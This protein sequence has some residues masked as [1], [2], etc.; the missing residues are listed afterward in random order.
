MMLKMYTIY[1]KKTKLYHPPHY[2]HNKE[3]AMRMFIQIMCKAGDTMSL[4]PQDFQMWELGTFDDCTG[5]IKTTQNPTLVCEVLDLV[6]SYEET[7]QQLQNRQGNDG[8]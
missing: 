2:C 5:R 3:H 6:Q 1:D 4:Y 7:K 8:S